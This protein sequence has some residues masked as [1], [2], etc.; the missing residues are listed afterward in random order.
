[1]RDT[2]LYDL[3]GVVERI[4]AEFDLLETA[5]FQ[6]GSEAYLHPGQQARVTLGELT[7]GT[8]GELHPDVLA[9]LE[10]KHSIYVFELDWH[11]LDETGRPE[12]RYRDFPRTPLVERDL[13]LVVEEGTEAGALLGFIRRQD[14]MIT[15]ARVFDLYRGGQVAAGKKSLAFSIRMGRPDRTLTDP[16]INEVFQR[17]IQGVCREFGAEVR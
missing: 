6:R 10:V 15:D 13:A 9:R 16:E 14:E 1:V 4:L 12:R 17:V 3:K 7:L 11:A 8:L 2:D 5:A